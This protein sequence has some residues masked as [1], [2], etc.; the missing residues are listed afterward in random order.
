MRDNKYL[1]IYVDDSPVAREMVIDGLKDT[2]Y[3]L[4]TANDA[5]DLESRHLSDP[6]TL[7]QVDLF[8]FDFD[9][10]EMTG[11]QIASVLDQLYKELKAI[12]FIIFSGRP[13]EEVLAS[14]AEASKYS[15][16]FAKNFRGYIEKKG[17]SV[18]ELIQKINEILL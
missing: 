6:N 7:W 16:T 13:R 5:A 11:T 10:P 8:I 14:I 18:A 15:S 2:N 3:L 17:D 9:M 4:E 12:P 1:V